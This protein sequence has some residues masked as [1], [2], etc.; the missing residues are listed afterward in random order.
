MTP[1]NFWAR[2]DKSGDCWIWTGSKTTAGYGNLTWNN[3]GHYA[4]RVA[5]EDA[6]GVIGEGLHLDHLCRVRAC[7]RPDHLEAVTQAENIRRGAGPYGPVRTTCKHGHDVSI[8]ENVYTTP[9][10]HRRCKVCAHALEAR[11]TADRRARGDLRK[12]LK[13]HCIAGHAFDE[14]NTYIAPDGRRSCR[15]CTARRAREKR[16]SCLSIR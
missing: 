12:V 6:N 4:H 7:V 11:R 2:V 15:A 16:R 8:P 1:A 3:K 10:G 13:S 14:S 9:S 5:Y